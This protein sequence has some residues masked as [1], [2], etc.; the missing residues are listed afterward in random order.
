MA[1]GMA[2]GRAPSPKGRGSGRGGGRG[3][4]RGAGRGG[5]RGPFSGGLYQPSQGLSGRGLYRAARGIAN[6]QV[7]GPMSELAA[8]TARNRQQGA[9]AQGQTFAYYMQLAKEA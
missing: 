3:G 6:A 1:P 4:N 8:Q 2:V 5:N 9:A 7:A